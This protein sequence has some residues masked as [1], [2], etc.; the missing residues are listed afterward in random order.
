[1][2]RVAA[3][4]ADDASGAGGHEGDSYAPS[5]AGAELLR[6]NNMPPPADPPP[7][8]ILPSPRPAATDPGPRKESVAS[9]FRSDRRRGGALAEALAP[10]MGRPPPGCPAALDVDW[11]EWGVGFRLVFPSSPRVG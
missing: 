11:G 8:P 1:M 2:G 7:P 5:P 10:R 9:R 3:L 6:D 4:Y